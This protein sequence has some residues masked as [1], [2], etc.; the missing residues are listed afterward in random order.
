MLLPPNE[1]DTAHKP[2]GFDMEYARCSLQGSQKYICC[3]FLIT[4]PGMPLLILVVMITE[5]RGLGELY[6]KNAFL[7]IENDTYVIKGRTLKLDATAE[8]FSSINKAT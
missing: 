1:T 6:L 4:K 3:G 2:Q 8:M 7:D 5:R